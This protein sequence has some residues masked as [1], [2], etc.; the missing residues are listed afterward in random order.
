MARLLGWAIGLLAA[1]ALTPALAQE[2]YK[3][4]S[5]SFIIGFGVSNGYDFYSRAV[6]RQIGKY[7]PG[8]PN[9]IVQNMPGAGSVAA[10]NHLYNV[11]PKDGTVLGM[12]D[13]AALLS[14]MLDPKL[15]RGDVTKFNWIGRVTDNAGV[16]YAWHT[17]PVQKIQ[18]AYDK[19]LIVATAG[20]NSRLLLALVKNLLGMKLRLLNGSQ[21]PADAALAMERGEVHALTQP[22]PVLRAE[23]PD[24]LRDRKVN[25]LMQSGVDSHPDLKGTPIVTELA[26]NQEERT[27]LE[28]VAGNS[29]I[30]RAVVSPPGQPLQRVVEL[31]AAFLQ[32]MKDAD[33]LEEIRRDKLDL[34]PMSGEELQKFIQ[35]SANIPPALIERAKVLAEFKE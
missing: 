7:L 11:A 3:G 28:F 13:Q 4:R 8:K 5:V 23:K 19:E 1:M 16:L 18:D 14:Q 31:R 26:R 32:V 21:G 29:R 2:F 34:A 20:Q 10:I 27:M 35:D 9:V 30:G 25:I 24:W 33:F 15:I 6:A 12:I 22:F 17:A